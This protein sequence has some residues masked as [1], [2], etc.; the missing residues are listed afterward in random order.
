MSYS[1]FH[2][3]S[4]SFVFSVGSRGSKC[5]ICIDSLAV[6]ILQSPQGKLDGLKVKKLKFGSYRAL[7]Q[8]NL[9]PIGQ[10]PSLEC[11]SSL[12][13]DPLMNDVTISEKECEVD[14]VKED[15]C[16]VSRGIT[17]QRNV[18]HFGYPV[19]QDKNGVPFVPRKL[20]TTEL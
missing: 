17:Y 16:N 20:E 12:K 15:E 13:D 3:S 18:Y 11:G 10:P 5:E 19:F 14:E 8:R 2:C 9:L 1:I 7:L 6:L 4:Q